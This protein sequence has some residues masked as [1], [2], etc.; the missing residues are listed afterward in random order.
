METVASPSA[1]EIRA[2]SAADCRR[3]SQPMRA[4][5]DDSTRPAPTLLPV[6]L[7]SPVRWEVEIIM[8]SFSSFTF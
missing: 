1:A 6:T 2:D 5:T 4:N 8:L 7:G 3:K